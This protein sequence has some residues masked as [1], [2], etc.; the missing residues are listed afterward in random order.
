MRKAIGVRTSSRRRTN[1]SASSLWPR[2]LT[3]SKSSATVIFIDV[4]CA[5][6]FPKQTNGAK[7][8]Y[9]Q[10]HVPLIMN[11][12][13]R[14]LFNVLVRQHSRAQFDVNDIGSVRGLGM[15][16]II[17]K[18]GGL[19]AAAIVATLVASPVLAAKTTKVSNTGVSTAFTGI[20]IAANNDN[21]QWGF[22]GGAGAELAIGGPW[23]AKV[24]YIY[25]RLTDDTVTLNFASF[26]NGAGTTVSY[27]FRNEGHIF[28]AG[29]NYKLGQ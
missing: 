23:S 10:E 16:R 4:R 12:E 21:I 15:I 20:T 17:K 6:R 28:R 24:E 29:F 14:I 8:S 13:I 3:F 22:A 7:I 26:P 25:Y 5:P 27:I 18:I 19:T 9:D 11:F 2:F 1:D